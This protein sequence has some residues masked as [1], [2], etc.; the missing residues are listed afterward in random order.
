MKYSFTGWQR[1]TGCLE[2]HVILRKRANNYGVLLRKMK[3]K[4]G[5]RLVFAILYD[6]SCPSLHGS[7]ALMIERIV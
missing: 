7:Y 6:T 4:E 5:I 1:P 3:S 2:L